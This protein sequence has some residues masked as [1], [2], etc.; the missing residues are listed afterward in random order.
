MN[1]RAGSETGTNATDGL[2]LAV[3]K[4]RTVSCWAVLALFVALTVYGF[5]Q[6]RLFREEIWTH[7]GLR[8]FL[9][10]T[11]GYWLCF[12]FFA[13]WRERMFPG[14]ILTVVLVYTIA[15]TGWLALPSAALVVLSSLVLGEGILERLR[16]LDD[17]SATS[18]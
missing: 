9:I 3:R 5:Y 16:V 8:R 13:L 11:A 6:A 15:A 4:I 2:T 1:T 12:G 17:G 7:A 10:F 14:F 18:S